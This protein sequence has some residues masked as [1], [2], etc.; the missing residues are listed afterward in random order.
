MFIVGSGFLVI[1]IIVFRF[2]ELNYLNLQ[3]TLDIP[4]YAMN[5]HDMAPSLEEYVR[6]SPLSLAQQLQMIS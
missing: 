3:N 2:I 5:P 1:S 4:R 6:A